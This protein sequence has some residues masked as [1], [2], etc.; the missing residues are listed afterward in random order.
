MLLVTDCDSKLSVEVLNDVKFVSI[1]AP[2]IGAVYA[3][4]RVCSECGV[5]GV[6]TGAARDPVYSKEP[7]HQKGFAW[8]FRSFI[9][10]KPE[11]AAMRLA[12]ILADIDARYRVV[13]IKPPK[14]VHFHVEWRG[15]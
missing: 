14:P 9:F 6:I 12:K 11:Q 10:E 8:D 7:L 2:A 1:N 5:V 13:Y 3:Y 4:N 15:K